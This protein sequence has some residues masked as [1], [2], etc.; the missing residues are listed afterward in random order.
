V[1]LHL[2]AAIAS[3]AICMTASSANPKTP[4]FTVGVG[5][6]EAVEVVEVENVE[7][8]NDEELLLEVET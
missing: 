3:P 5:V 4:E 7:E 1:L 6:L 2:E 8:D